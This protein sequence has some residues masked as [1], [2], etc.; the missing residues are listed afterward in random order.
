MLKLNILN[1]Y[2]SHCF[3]YL[4]TLAFNFHFYVRTCIIYVRNMKKVGKD[5]RNAKLN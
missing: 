3:I 4:A 2:L 5:D 1:Q